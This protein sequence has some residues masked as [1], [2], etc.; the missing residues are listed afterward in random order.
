MRIPIQYTIPIDLLYPT[1]IYLYTTWEG[2]GG[3]G[4]E[5][6]NGIRYTLTHINNHV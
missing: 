4:G 1:S 5:E 3:G 2:G 6:W